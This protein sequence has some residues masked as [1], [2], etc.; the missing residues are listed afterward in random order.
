MDQI[1]YRRRTLSN[2]A[3]HPRRAT[4][5]IS[6]WEPVGS[7]R[8]RTRVS[9]DPAGGDGL[10]CTIQ[11]TRYS[12]SVGAPKISGVLSPDLVA[13]QADDAELY[14]DA[15]GDAHDVGEFGGEVLRVELAVRFTLA[16]GA[17][18]DVDLLGNLAGLLGQLND[19]LEGTELPRVPDGQQLSGGDQ[20]RKHPVD[21]VSTRVAVRRWARRTVWMRSWPAAFNVL[22]GGAVRS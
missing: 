14:C 21:V 5:D 12:R 19:T 17:G 8:G 2:G 20:E 16:A 7:R 4:T 10:V 6:L 9:P 18:P 13:D 1:G 22:V 3:T 15:S 11:A